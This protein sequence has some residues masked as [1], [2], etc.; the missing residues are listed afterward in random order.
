MASIYNGNII[1]IL[2]KAR[3]L[4]GTPNKATMSDNN[5]IREA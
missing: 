3:G 1:K 5:K 2:S 4:A